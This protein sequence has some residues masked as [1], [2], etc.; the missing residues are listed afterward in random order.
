MNDS[1]MARG[2]TV[3]NKSGCLHGGQFSYFTFPADWINDRK[4]SL[5]WVCC[6]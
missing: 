3:C 6:I 4:K 1:D 2:L 5:Y